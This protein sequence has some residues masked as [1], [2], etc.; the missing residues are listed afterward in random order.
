MTLSDPLTVLDA[1]SA[2]LEA[3]LMQV[4][5]VTALA[6][7]AFRVLAAVVVHIASLVGLIGREALCAILLIG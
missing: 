1:V 3:H 6:S 5:V 4:Q 7:G 2:P